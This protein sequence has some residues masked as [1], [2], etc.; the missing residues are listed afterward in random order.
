M[1]RKQKT[2]RASFSHEAAKSTPWPL[3]APRQNLQN[4]GLCC[5]QII[6]NQ[7]QKRSG[8]FSMPSGSDSPSNKTHTSW[9]RL[10]SRPWC[11]AASHALMVSKAASAG[12]G[13]WTHIMSSPANVVNFAWRRPGAISARPQVRTKV[14]GTSRSATC[15]AS[16]K[17]AVCRC[18]GAAG[19]SARTE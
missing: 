18:G 8:T 17:A 1:P 14:G 10:S 5:A 3:C 4:H 2:T 12:D 13:H 16:S 19:S 11:A 7:L 6:S 15:L 9:L